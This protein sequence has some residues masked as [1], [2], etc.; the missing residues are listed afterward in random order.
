[1][2]TVL[3]QSSRLVSVVLFM[4]YGMSMFAQRQDILLNNDWNFRFSHQVQK[5][6]GVRVDLPHTWNAQDALSGKIDYKRGIGNYEKNLFIRPEWKGKRLFI[7]FEGV[8]NIADVFINRRHI[9]EHRG[10]YGAFIFEITGKVEYGKE[11]S[12]LVR[13]N[14]GEQL[15]IMPLVGDFNF[16]GGI[17]RDVHLLITDETCI[18]PLDYASPGVRLIQDSVSHRYAKVRAIVDLSNGSSG[19]QEVEL[20][21]RLLDGQRVVKEGTKNVNLS[22]NEVMQQE[23]TFEIDQPHLWNGRQDTF[24]YQAE[25]TLFRNGQMVDRVTQPL[26]LRFYRIDPDKGFFLNGKHL[27]LQGVCRHQDRSEVGNALRPQHHEEDVALMLE[28]GVNAVRL[29]HYPQATYFYDLMDKNGIIVWA[30]IPFVGPGGYNDKGFVDLPAFRANG[31]EQLKELIRQHY[32]HPSICVW[33][34]FNE[35]TELGDNPVEY[36]KKLNVLAHQEDTTRPT[37]SASNQMGDLNFITDAIAWNRYDGWYG[38]TPADLGK[39]LDRMHK[40]HPEI[41]IAISE[42]GAGASIYHQQDSLVKTVPTS[43]WHP[44]NWQTYYHIENWKTISS[45]PYVWGS[46]VWNMFDFGAAHRTEGDRPG[47]NDK[48]LVTFDRKVRKDAFYFYKANWN[49]EEPMLYLTGKRN[50]VRTQHLQTIT[51]FTN[52]SGAELFVNGKSY[53]KAI[54]D[55]YAILEWKN[56][57]LEPGENEIKVVSTNKKLPLSD[58]FH[59][60]L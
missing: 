50:T 48:G 7:R 25:V 30:E 28:M 55:S 21:V 14:N 32:N 40:D 9:G 34:L 39:W 5:G 26:G 12:I 22:G 52:L 35:L 15:D 27:P 36:I 11:N 53:G 20:N 45:R 57:E 59:C 43:W 13:V 33:G 17:Y 18:S 2:K 10:G 31:K 42:Y 49:R 23:L 37:T 54:P 60:R 56:V 29:A 6:T 16:Y 58:S 3:L 44:E 38:G 51:A 24:L 47:I 4:L 41:C 1:M 46:F 8:N 19:N